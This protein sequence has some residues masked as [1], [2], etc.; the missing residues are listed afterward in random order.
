MKEGIGMLI[1]IL[2]AALAGAVV[3]LQTVFNNKVNEK[4]GS[5]TTTTTVLGMGFLCSFIVSLIVEG[6]N[7][8]ELQNLQTWQWFGGV[9]G[10]GVVFC[11]VQVMKRLG[12]TFTISIVLTSQL[13]TALLWDSLGWLG[14]EKIPFTFNKLLGVLVI[15]A[16]ILVFKF[17]KGKEGKN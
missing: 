3:S 11:L 13:G 6:K 16:G 2:L 8:F 1:G 12:P 5:W 7:T 9:I 15:I 4:T 10:V 17:G 14:L